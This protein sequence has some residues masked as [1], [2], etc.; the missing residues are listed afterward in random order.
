MSV[1]LAWRNLIHERAKLILSVAG[2]AVSMTLIVI[3]VGFRDGMYTSMT[4]YYDHLPADL[5][6]SQSDTTLAGT[7]PVA[8]HD[9]LAAISGAVAT[10]HVIAAGII[11]THGSVKIA[12]ALVGYNPQTG[13]G[14]PWTLAQGRG[15][16]TNDE[17]V[18]DA[19]LA[20]ESR[21]AIGDRVDLLGQS[22]TVV[23]LSRETNSWVGYYIFVARAAAE[24]LLKFSGMT[25]FYVIRLPAGADNMAIAHAI[26]TQIAGVKATPPARIADN[27]RKSVGAILDGTLNAL[28]L[29]SIVIGIAV[30]GL[31]A[32][33][34]VI[35]QTREYGVIKALGANSWRLARLVVSETLYRAVFG[36]GLGVVLSYLITDLL[37][38]VVPRWN[39]LM[40][41]ETLLNT[42]LVALVMTVIAALLPIHRIATVDPA[43]VFKS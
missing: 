9:K 35:D 38:Q 11:F 36:F 26:E 15:V 16:Q 41:P 43:V 10:E 14:G 31:T 23:G 32:Y 18:L 5:L 33:T 28:L 37:T 17:I 8:L 13:I 7:I 6:V 19:Q 24:T 29:V 2:I 20:Q 12:V 1:P 3:L 22:F 30:M 40:R 42:G 39:V 25:S 4:A 34:A 27:A 21:L